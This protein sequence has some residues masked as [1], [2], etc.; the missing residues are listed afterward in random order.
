VLFALGAIASVS[1][2]TPSAAG[3][4]CACA[5]PCLVP[6]PVVEVVVPYV[7]PY[8]VVDQGPVYDGPGI[9]TVPTI[10]YFH[11]PLADYPYVTHVYSYPAYDGGPVWRH[12][13]Y[14][15]YK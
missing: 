3:S 13:R 2:V 1:A 9:V 14:H 5:T 11:T 6:A 8:Y 4:C 10:K 15:P 7:K 12:R